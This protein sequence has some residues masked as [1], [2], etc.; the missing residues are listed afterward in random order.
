MSLPG[1]VGKRATTPFFG[2]ERPE[3]VKIMSAKQPAGQPATLQSVASFIRFILRA[4]CPKGINLK[5]PAS[6]KKAVIKSP[7]STGVP[8][9][10]MCFLFA[11]CRTFEN[12]LDLV[13]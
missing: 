12:M 2:V 11:T 10:S 8:V 7:R 13:T 1:V 3:T 5:Q 9:P 6:V 4:F